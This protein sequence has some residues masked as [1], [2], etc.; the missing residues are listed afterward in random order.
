MCISFRIMAQVFRVA[1]AS[2]ILC[3]SLTVSNSFKVDT[4]NKLKQVHED[5]LY[6]PSYPLIDIF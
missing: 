5:M 2:R 6:N 3:C 4:V 1:S